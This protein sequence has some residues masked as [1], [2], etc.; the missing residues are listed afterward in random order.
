MFGMSLAELNIIQ[1]SMQQA[2]VTSAQLPRFRRALAQ[3]LAG[4][5]NCPVVVA[6]NSTVFGVGST[7]Q[8]SEPNTNVWKQSFPQQ[9]ASQLNAAGVSASCNGIVCSN[10]DNSWNIQSSDSR[11]TFGGTWGLL[12]GTPSIGGGLFQANGAGTLVFTPA[13]SC[14]T[15]RVRYVQNGS[16]G[17]M[18]LAVGAG[19]VTNVNTSGMTAFGSATVSGVL[20]QPLNISWVNGQLYTATI[21]GWDSAKASVIITNAGWPGAKLSDIS[22][23]VGPFDPFP[24]LLAFN[25]VL[26]IVDIGINDWNNGT[27]LATFITELMSF[28]TR[29]LAVSDVIIASPAPSSTAGTGISNATQLGFVQALRNAATALKIPFVDV[30]S[31]WGDWNANQIF[32]APGNT[33]F[34]HPNMNGYADYAKCLVGAML[35]A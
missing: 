10:P 4:Q 16:L 25:Q 34:I 32:Y 3:T 23:G 11:L 30:W 27:P 14:D 26:T 15:Y 8:V 33:G 29:L 18:G 2:G 22:G 19:A 35:A 6:G 9:I 1:A 24:A 21:E 5:A 20:G 7:N 13:S 28:L 17:T 12:H 31:R